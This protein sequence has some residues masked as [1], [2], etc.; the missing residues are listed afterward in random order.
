MNRHNLFSVTQ[1]LG[2]LEGIESKNYKTGLRLYHISNKKYD[3][4]K[5]R[6]QQGDNDKN[7]PTSESFE[8]NFIL[9]KIT[10]EDIKKYVE[11]GFK[12]WDMEETYLYIINPADI[13]DYDYASITSTPEQREYDER[14]WDDSGV[15]DDDFKAWKKEYIKTREQFLWKEYKIPVQGLLGEFLNHPKY[16]NW[17]SHKWIDE[18][19]KTGNKNQ[20]ASN[21]PHLQIRVNQP[22]KPESVIKLK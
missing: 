10:K 7:K 22:I 6:Q 11:A 19:L 4:L 16:S 18:N 14:V 15:S 13:T 8:I 5:S 1:Y 12:R 17:A 3:V 20:Y 9:A 2:D 21:I